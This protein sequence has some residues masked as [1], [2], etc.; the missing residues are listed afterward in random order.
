MTARR[1]LFLLR[2]DVTYLNH[3]SFGAC[4][5][6]VFARYQSLQRELEAEPVDFLD[7]RRTL[8]D[9]LADAR[10]RLA[11]YLGAE[12]DEL[13]FVPNA[14]TGLNIA[15]RSLALAPGDEILACDHEY[16]AMDRMWRFLCAKQEARYIRR[17]LPLP[18]DV[19]GAVV[20]AVWSGV[21]DRTRVLF[22]SHITS[23][24]GVI[25]PVEPLIARAREHGI[26]TMID[27]AHVPGQI[28]CDLH[29]LG[30]DIWAG[31]C[32]KWLLAPKGAA[33]LYVRNEVQH[34]VEPLIV[35]WGWQSE[36]P[37]PSRFVDEQEWTGTR[38]PSAYLAVPAAL[39]F[40][41]EHDW[42]A[43]RRDCRDLLLET[44]DRLLEVVGLPPLCP[45]QPWLAQ[46]AAIP[47]PPGTDA[48]TFGHA[49]RHEFAIEVPVTRF[50]DR[51]WLRFSIQGYNT[52]EDTDRLCTAVADL[53][54][55]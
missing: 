29:A 6:P 10:G 3:G 24:S 22:L 14:T 21:T 34:L 5:R 26:L 53:L 41:A 52:P 1:D 2:D 8:T 49:L 38:D 35:S 25:L 18:L 43:V 23:P 12:R 40:L 16:G 30:C 33:A 15:A 20:E 42:A 28:D 19:P 13:V 27:G 36:N 46:M 44:R 17:P 9:R 32:H 4:P 7:S 48:E 39:D 45:P 55:R 37:G 47:L 51:P 11:A 54:R 50:A 31:N